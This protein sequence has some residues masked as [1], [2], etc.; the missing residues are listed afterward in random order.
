VALPA[1]N[2]GE[3]PPPSAGWRNTS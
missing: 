2:K 1:L 3:G